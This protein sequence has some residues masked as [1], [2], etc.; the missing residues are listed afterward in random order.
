MS[1]DSEELEAYE[2]AHHPIPDLSGPE[3][4]RHLLIER[5]ISQAGAARE[6]GMAP[7]TVSEILRGKRGIGRKHLD[8]FARYFHVSPAV[9]LPEV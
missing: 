9:F 2:R 8:A 6:M 1:E 7:S 5:G 3:M 4:L